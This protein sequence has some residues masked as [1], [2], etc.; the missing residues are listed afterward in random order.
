MKYK[1]TTKQ[2]AALL[3]AYQNGGRIFQAPGCRK[4]HPAVLARL[5]ETG[6]LEA[7]PAGP[8]GAVWA[9]TESGRTTLTQVY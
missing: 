4:H 7:A 6:L 1:L 9:L 2:E 3:D 8:T 5:V